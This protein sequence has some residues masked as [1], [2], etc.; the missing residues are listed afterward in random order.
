MCGSQVAAQLPSQ[1]DKNRRA[2]ARRRSRLGGSE[3]HARGTSA[4][5]RSCRCVLVAAA[6]APLPGGRHGRRFL[7]LRVSALARQA[8]EHRR[9][10]RE[11]RSPTAANA[12]PRQARAT[13]CRLECERSRWCYTLLYGSAI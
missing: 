12:A 5:V 9:A 4:A 11:N 13:V 7:Q 1:A 8:R 10:K 2:L 3:L 6:A